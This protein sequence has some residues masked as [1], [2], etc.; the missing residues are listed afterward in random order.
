M[1]RVDKVSDLGVPKDTIHFSIL[2]LAETG[3]N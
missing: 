1:R 2:L 3:T